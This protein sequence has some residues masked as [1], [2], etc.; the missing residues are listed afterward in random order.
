[1]ESK[2][3]PVDA[4]LNLSPGSGKVVLFNCECGAKDIPIKWIDFISGRR[5]SCGKC[6]LMSA[7]YWENARFGKLMMTD[8]IAIS[9]GSNKKVSWTCDCGGSVVASVYTVFKGLTLTCGRCK[10]IKADEWSKKT[11]GRLRMKHPVDMHPSSSKSVAWVCSCGNEVDIPVIRVTKFNT[12]SCGK[13]RNKIHEWYEKNRDCLLSIKTPIDPNDLPE[14]GVKFSQP[15]TRTGVPV[16][17]T[18]PVC[19]SEYRPRWDDIRLGKSLTC[20]C[21]SGHIS[22]AQRKIHQLLVSYGAEAILE[23]KIGKFSYDIGVPS[24]NILIEYHGLRWHSTP[25]SKQR[26]LKKYKNAIDHGHDVIVIYEDEWTSKPGV[27]LDIMVNRLGVAPSSVQLRPKQCSIRRVSSPDADSFYEQFHYIGKTRSNINYAA[28]FDGRC[29]CILSFKHPT[30]QSIHEWELVRMASD[31]EFH[32]HGIWSKLMACFIENFKPLSI[33]SFSDNRLFTGKTY[34][35]LGF[36]F[37]GQVKP[38]YYWVK[39]NRRF[40]KSNLRKPVGAT[41]T[42][43]ELRTK[44]GFAKIWDLG[45]KRWVRRFTIQ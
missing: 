39:G 8:P 31:P 3:T 22:D 42:E 17:A 41:Q 37:D 32:I 30:R 36:K 7:E 6:N 44:Q 9:T 1:M 29:L 14:Y 20:G 19:G 15:I 45:K 35:K 40:N 43:N 38:D 18:C 27:M 34:E 28:F 2:L 33:V 24:H 10:I 25:E 4:S 11:F 12:K 21:A 13:C 16:S 5:K 26:D 23:H